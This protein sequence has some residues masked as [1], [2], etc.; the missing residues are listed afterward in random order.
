MNKK[1][2]L[3]QVRNERIQA[4]FSKE[5]SKKDKTQSILSIYA[6]LAV[7]FDLSIERIREIVCN[8][9]I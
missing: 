7:E 8:R 2:K 3:L 1:S 9:R 5:L 6:H 4:L